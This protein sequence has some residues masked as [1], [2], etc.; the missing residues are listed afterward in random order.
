MLLSLVGQ[1]RIMVS[2]KSNYTYRNTKDT[3]TKEELRMP[4]LYKG[5]AYNYCLDNNT[6]RTVFYLAKQRIR[7]SAPN[8][9]ID[10]IRP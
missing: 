4:A 6:Q 5:V 8:S 7:E 10:E 2:P 9:M 3:Y 1:Q